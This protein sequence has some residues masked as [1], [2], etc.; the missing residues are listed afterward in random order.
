M[1]KNKS[2]KVPHY[3]ILYLISNKYTEEEVKPINEEVKKIITDNNGQ[4]TFIEEWGKRKLAYPIKHFNHGYY[5]LLECDLESSQVD[6]IDQAL[7]LSNK[8]LRHMIVVKVAKTVEEVAKE[9]QLIIERQEKTRLKAEEKKKAVEP[10]VKE[11]ET[12]KKVNLKDLDEKLDKILD[13]NDLL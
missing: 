4:I 10:P 3:E 6:K 12:K 5:N 2:N 7:K 9:K 11:E 1:A 13:T 8:I